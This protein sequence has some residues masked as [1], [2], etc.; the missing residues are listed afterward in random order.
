[1]R[2]SGKSHRTLSAQVGQAA[3]VKAT[4]CVL[5]GML[6][7]VAAEVYAGSSPAQPPAGS[8]LPP[9]ERAN[10]AQ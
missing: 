10:H 4:E 3:K 5:A 7:L 9:R 8:T 1:M 6:G 2:S